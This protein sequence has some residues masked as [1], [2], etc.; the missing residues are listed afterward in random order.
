M[1]G[2]SVQQNRS[3]EALKEEL[4]RL[5]GAHD[6]GA[7]RVIRKI[8]RLGMERN[9]SG[10]IGYA[11]YR[12]AYFYY[13]L[14]PDLKK[15]RQNLQQAIHYLLRSNDMEFLGGAYNLIAYDAL[16]QGRFD[17]A[18][19][20]FMIAVKAAEQVKDIALPGL[21]EANAGRL[22]VEIGDR[23]KGRQQLRSAIRRMKAFPTMHVYHYNM[24]LTHAEV[25][26]ASFLLEDR[27]GVE[28]TLRQIE[29]HYEEAD[30]DEKRISQTY[31]SLSV[32]YRALL[33]N[34]QK[35]LEKELKKLL[36]NWKE[37]SAE[38]L[39]G[40]IFE[41]ESLCNYLV[42]HGCYR[43]VKQILTAT[44]SLEKSEN[45]TVAFRYY[46][47]KILL[48]EKTKENANLRRCLL[49]Q[50]EIQKKEKAEAMR[51]QQYTIEFADLIEQIA[52]ERENAQVESRVLR[53]QINTDA[54]TA[55]PN[56]NAINKML[57]EK[58]EEA[59]QNR[60]MFGIGILDV[61]DFKNYNDVYGHQAGDECLKLVA[62]ILLPYNDDPHLFCARYGGD[63]FLVGYFGLTDEEI[64]KI[65]TEMWQ[66]VKKQTRKP[67]SRAKRP[68]NISQGI[69]NE[70]P[71][72]GQHFW[73]YL[74][75]ADEELYRVKRRGDKKCR[76]RADT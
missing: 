15:F 7:L 30:E 39:G 38:E 69:Y 14:E 71:E 31:Y 24:L 21:L 16:D 73:D 5:L 8:H 43:T 58:F 47:Q 62:E 61:D 9:D 46:T 45:L 3:I 37:Q 55:L 68:V 63:E 22:L 56:R 42:E 18:Y 65:A 33:A 32:I 75:L 11:Y 2:P 20:Y 74:P 60:T 67:N 13:F 44:V 36:S 50:R 57:S 76:D 41:I 26:L 12:Y 25:A 54:L 70:V 49:A 40:L 27:P 17:I 35:T 66:T 34:D 10:A 52:I 23:R 53:E 1:S 51:L 4:M 28:A 64:L 59:L 19:A 29:R 6:P 48:Y 72:E